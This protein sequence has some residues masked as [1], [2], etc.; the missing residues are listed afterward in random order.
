MV[1]IR[2]VNED[3][4]FFYIKHSLPSQSSWAYNDIPRT[5][6]VAEFYSKDGNLI[7]SKEVCKEN[8]SGYLQFH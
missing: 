2:I 6:K 5:A 4:S 3:D 7:L 1:S 8:S